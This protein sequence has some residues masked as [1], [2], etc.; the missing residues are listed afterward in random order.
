[1]G[2]WGR[3]TFCLPRHN[4]SSVRDAL[5][6][7]ADGGATGGLLRRAPFCGQ[8]VKREAAK[9]TSYLIELMKSVVDSELKLVIPYVT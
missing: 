5:W 1:M 4:W 3:R 7:T 9:T 6:Q 2:R 8:E